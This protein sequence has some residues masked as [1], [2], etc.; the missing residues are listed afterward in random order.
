M[1]EPHDFTV[2][3]I[4]FVG[5][6]HTLRHLAAHRFPHSTYRDDRAYAP[7]R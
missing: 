7:H 6:K 5:V 2:R 1:P 3:K 4:A